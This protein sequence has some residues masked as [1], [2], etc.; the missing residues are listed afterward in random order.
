MASR[1]YYESLWEGIPAGISPS[2]A[3]L[4]EAFLLSR[5]AAERERVG[6]PPRV[7]DLGCG[8]GYFAAALARGGAE[9]VA[10]DVAEAALRRART[11]HPE[12]DVRL[13]EPEAPLPLEDS[14]FDVVWAGETIEHVA[15][16]QQW[17]SEVRRVLRSGGLILI[18]TPDHGFLTRLRLALSAR[19]FES[20][21]DP[22]ADHLRFYTRRVLAGL[23][24]GFGFEE[25]AVAGRRG[26]PG[27]RRVLLASGRR[28][29][30]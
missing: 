11:S 7:L 20:H 19:A 2:D 8:E 4:R 6:D 25:V 22:L 18:S 5:V 9:V 28:A 14:S 16:T 17:L 27:A 10:V 1:A 30:F 23:L 26:T 21:F 13:A 15:D 12:L 3:S 29:R 24:A